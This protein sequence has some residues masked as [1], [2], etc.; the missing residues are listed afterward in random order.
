M[1]RLHEKM[2]IIKICGDTKDRIIA[3]K[4]LKRKLRQICIATLVLTL[5][6]WLMRRLSVMMPVYLS[7]S[8]QYYLRA[9]YTIAKPRA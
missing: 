7:F 8:V 9:L 5:L 4:G 6:L 1:H 3:Y 2:A